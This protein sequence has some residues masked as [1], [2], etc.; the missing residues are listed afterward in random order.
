MSFYN[1]EVDLVKNNQ[2][3]DLNGKTS[4]NLDSITVNSNPILD[5]GVSNKKYIDNE[6]DKNTILRLSQTL[7]NYL[8]KTVGNDTYNL[9]RHDKIQITDAR[10]VKAPNNGGYLLQNWVIFC[11]D[12]NGKGKISNFVEPTETN[13]PTG[14]SGATSLPL[15]GDSFMYIETSCNIKGDN[16]FCSFER[17]DIIQISN[18][19]FFYKRFSA[20]GTKSMGRFRVQLVDNNTWSTQY[21]IHKNDRYS[22][23]ST[24]WTLSKLDFT[25]EN[26]GIKLI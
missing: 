25:V 6:I 26:Y 3:N 2:D 13:S 23:T 10:I 17:T 21:T 7:E 11:N 14:D 12:K 20:G 8:K 18:I 5:E 1:E 4:T 16:V 15:R 9:T 24:D 19:T 22:D